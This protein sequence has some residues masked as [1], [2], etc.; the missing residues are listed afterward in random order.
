MGLS[1][2]NVRH[3]LPI[4]I[5]SNGARIFVEQ[6]HGFLLPPVNLPPVRHTLSSLCF[7]WQVDQG[8][9]QEAFPFLAGILFEVAFPKYVHC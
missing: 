6:H 7:Q 3:D 4:W 5:P 9:W 8:G 2:L 1:E